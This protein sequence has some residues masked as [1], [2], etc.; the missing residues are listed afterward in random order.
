[1][2]DQWLGTTSLDEFRTKYL[3]RAAIAQPATVRDPASQFGWH[4]LDDV[5]H[6]EAKLDILVVARGELLPLPPPRSFAELRAY[7]AT[8]IGLCIRGAERHPLF[9][10]HV[11]QLATIGEPRVQLFV[12]PGGTHGFGWHYDDEDVFIS[13]T[14]G[15]KQYWFRSN[16]V[17]SGRAAPREFARFHS[18]QSVLQAADLIAGDFLYLPAR[19]WHMATCSHD[20]LSISIGVRRH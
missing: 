4:H 13:Q 15:A 14:A 1:M 19:W 12:T 7:F 11:A 17:T 3:G 8:G 6:S 20:A 9:A 16:T 2:L 10:H 5:L 18:E